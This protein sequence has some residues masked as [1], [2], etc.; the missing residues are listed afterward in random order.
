MSS[1]REL[2]NSYDNNLELLLSIETYIPRK[3][4]KYGK[5]KKKCESNEIRRTDEKSSREYL[6]ASSSFAI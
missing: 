1:H 4:Y 6:E 2:K 5:P 3:R